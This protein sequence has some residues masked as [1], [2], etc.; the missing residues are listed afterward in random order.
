MEKVET[1]HEELGR[2]WNRAGR[3]SEMPFGQLPE[4]TVEQ[5]LEMPAGLPPGMP[6]AQHPETLAG[7]RGETPVVWRASA[8]SK[9]RSAK[10]AEIPSV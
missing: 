9:R 4:M 10:T 1:N 6:V 5:P 3:Q 8:T 7:L 2:P